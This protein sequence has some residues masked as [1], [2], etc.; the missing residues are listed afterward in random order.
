MSTRQRTQGIILH[1]QYSKK[2]LIGKNTTYFRMWA[3][4]QGSFG[5]SEEDQRAVGAT[6]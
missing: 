2:R 6:K 1:N 4:T 3:A 5:L